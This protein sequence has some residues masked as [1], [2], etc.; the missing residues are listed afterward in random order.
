MNL[1]KLGDIDRK[2]AEEL[3]KRSGT[4]IERLETMID[5]H[6]YLSGVIPFLGSELGCKVEVFSADDPDK[7]D[8]L[9][10]ARH[11]QPRRPA[12]YIE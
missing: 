2:L 12:I 8:P 10:K 9:N 7:A 4:E 5:E 6:A 11:A 3:M 1:G